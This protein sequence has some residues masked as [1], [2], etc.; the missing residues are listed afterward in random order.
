[1]QNGK[2]TTQKITECRKTEN[3]S[4]L[5]DIMESQPDN[6]YYLSEEKVQQLLDRL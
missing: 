6:R 2:F 1:M 5:L 3:V 4:T